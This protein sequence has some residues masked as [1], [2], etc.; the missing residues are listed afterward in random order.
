MIV[1]PPVAS[2]TGS[3]KLI[4]FPTPSEPLPPAVLAPPAAV[5]VLAFSVMMLLLAVVIVIAPAS[6][7][8]PVTAKV[9]APPEVVM[10]ASAI[11]PLAVSIV[12]A[13]PA[14]PA[15]RLLASPVVTMLPTRF[16]VPAP[17]TF[18]STAPEI[19]PS[20]G[21]AVAVVVM[22]PP[23]R[24]TPPATAFNVTRPS[25]P[26]VVVVIPS[27]K[28]I[29][30]A[31]RV[32]APVDVSKP[33][34]CVV[35][36]PLVDWLKPAL[37]NVLVSVT[38][39]AAFTVTAPRGVLPPTAPV[40][41]MLPV[42]DVNAS[43]WPPF[44]VLSNRISPAVAPV[45]IVTP[46]VARV[47]GSSK[48]IVA[49]APLL[50]PVVASL[51]PPAAVNVLALS[52]IAGLPVSV[53]IVIAPAAPPSPATLTQVEAPPDV[54]MSASAIVPLSVSIVTAPPAEPTPALFA[55]PV[56]TRLPTRF[57]V[58]V[59]DTSMSIAPDAVPVFTPAVVV[60]DLPVARSTNVV[61]FKSTNPPT[62]VTSLLMSIVAVVK[63][64][65]VAPVVKATT[66]FKAV[67]PVPAD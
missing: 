23:V 57:T 61:A 10:S 38:S 24:S 18:M 2:E 36:V 47:T 43:V 6:P 12:T 13:P 20:F 29:V 67:V 58:P 40:K 42:P 26:P 7:P 1:T 49:P 30:T 5:N 48:L 46:P 25:A 59:P 4:V 3:S 27:F 22:L 63:D 15:V 53:V 56:V 17:V 66:P 39:L 31:P 33:P 45:V 34:T 14:E 11:V 60:I 16:T 54:V 52:V 55:A 65:C 37:A 35:P 44:K 62:V 19:T 9:E 41:T 51:A 64:S 21:V 32:T 50:V 28:S 8:L